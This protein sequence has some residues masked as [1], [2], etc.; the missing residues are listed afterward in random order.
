MGLKEYGPE[1][2]QHR[3]GEGDD[4]ESMLGTHCFPLVEPVRGPGCESGGPR[5]CTSEHRPSR[6]PQIVNVPFSLRRKV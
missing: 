2:D 4:G 6:S 1:H 5:R 3:D